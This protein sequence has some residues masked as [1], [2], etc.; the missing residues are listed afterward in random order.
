MSCAAELVTFDMGLNR[1]IYLKSMLDQHIAVMKL[2]YG[3]PAGMVP[4]PNI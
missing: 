4:R 1:F 3:D 2:P